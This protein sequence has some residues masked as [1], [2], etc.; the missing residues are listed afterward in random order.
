MAAYLFTEFDF[1]SSAA[2]VRIKEH[3]NTNFKTT[4]KNMRDENVGPVFSHKFRPL[5]KPVIGATTSRST[6][7]IELHDNSSQHWL[8]DVC[9]LKPGKSR[10]EF[11]QWVI[12]VS[13]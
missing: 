2:K 1:H 8:W 13:F 9:Y 5:L 12:L 7:N 4:V 11:L 10:R 6:F 3:C